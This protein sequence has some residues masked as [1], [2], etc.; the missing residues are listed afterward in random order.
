[1]VCGTVLLI[2]CATA[3]IAADALYALRTGG[4]KGMQNL[5]IKLPP[6]RI[7]GAVS[8]EKA[9]AE[10]RSV[11]EFLSEALPLESVSQLLWAAQGLCAGSGYRTAPSAGALY[12]LELYLVAGDVVSLAPGVYRYAPRT[13]EIALVR[14]G[15]RRRELCAA[16]LGQDS[17]GSAQAVIVIA[18]VYGRI[19]GKYHQRGIRYAHI[20]C[21][22]AAQNLYL[23][24]HTL[25][26]GTVAIG[27]FDDARVKRVLEMDEREEPLYLLPAGKPRSR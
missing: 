3:S 21:G 27:A 11:R 5:K 20:E 13:H 14:P 2:A 6:P 23:Q 10:R 9:L 22:H 17:V 4:R 8:V 18:A 26:L 7:D 25:G 16:A 12:P 19:T 1:M 24:A 15:D